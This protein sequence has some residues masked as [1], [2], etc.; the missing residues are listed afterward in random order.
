MTNKSQ[1][2]PDDDHQ[3]GMLGIQI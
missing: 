3:A 1:G 2:G